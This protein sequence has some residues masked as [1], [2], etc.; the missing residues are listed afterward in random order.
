[1]SFSAPLPVVLVIRRWRG[2]GSS[3]FPP[4]AGHLTTVLI[5]ITEHWNVCT[6][7]S[8]PIQILRESG[9]RLAK[10]RIAD[11]DPVRFKWRPRSSKTSKKQNKFLVALIPGKTT[12]L[13][14]A[15]NTS[16]CFVNYCINKYATSIRIRSR[17]PNFSA[18]PD[19]QLWPYPNRNSLEVFI[20][21]GFFRN[22]RSCLG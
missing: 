7:A 19:L 16:R 15:I 13:Y 12:G 9:S 20:A 22:D 5:I 4:G 1:M 17:D 18:N 2:E 11:T 21:S 8:F 14:I 10:T 3:L 6:T